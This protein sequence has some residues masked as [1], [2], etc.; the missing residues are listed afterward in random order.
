MNTQTITA[1]AFQILSPVLLAALTWVAARLAQFINARVR[2]EYLRSVFLR[3]DDAVLSVVRELN[4]VMVDALKAAAPGGKL[5]IDV[6]NNIK[7]G[8][9]AALKQYLGTKGLTEIA[10][11]LAI[12]DA[13][14]D[15]LLGTRIEAAVN[16]LKSPPPVT[17]GV[18][19]P[20]LLSPVA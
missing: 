14:L 10:R 9:L 18:N 12:P 11:V 5:P 1:H 13:S 17:N 3:L 6:G 4:Q 16:Q 15:R 2:Q 8:A 7:Q 19:H 20:P